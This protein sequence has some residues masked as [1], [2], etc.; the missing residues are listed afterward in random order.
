MMSTGT[1]RHQLDDQECLTAITVAMPLQ[2]VVPER[3]NPAA[4]IAPLLW[5]QR[6][7]SPL[8]DIGDN[9]GA[10]FFFTCFVLAAALI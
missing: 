2:W 6:L 1:L 10:R 9:E 7:S 3:L 8:L 4:G 5:D